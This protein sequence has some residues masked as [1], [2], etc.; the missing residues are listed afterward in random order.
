MEGLSIAQRTPPTLP[1]RTDIEGLRGIAVLLVVLYHAG[2]PGFSGGYIGV[3]VFF[4]L[5]GYLITSILVKEVEETGTVDLLRFYVR[6]ARRLLPAAALL[7]VFV[8]GFTFVF[9][10]PLAQVDM[11]KTAVATAA[12]VSNIFFG[13]RATDYLAADADTNPLLHTWSLSVEEQFYLVWPMLVSVLL[14]GSSAFLKRARGSSRLNRRR[15]TWGMAVVA[16]ASFA[17]TLFLVETGQTH[18]AFFSSPTRVWEF[19]FGG[20]GALVP[21]VRSRPRRTIFTQV[22]GWAGLA[23]I[24]F[25]SS[26]YTE[27]TPFPGWTA[28]LPVLGTVFVLRAGTAQ[29]ERSLAQVL[30][31]RPL[32]F[33]GRLS[34]SWYLWHWPALVFA[35]EFD[36]NLTLAQKLIIVTVSLGFAEMSYRLVEN[37]VRRNPTFNRTSYG[38]TLLSVLAVF[39]L[40]LGASWWSVVA[41]ELR[42]P[43]QKRYVEARADTPRFSDWRCTVQRMETR[44]AGCSDGPADAAF[45]V[46]LFGDSHAAQWA[47][48]LQAVVAERNWRL[49]Y[50]IKVGCPALD[51]T[52]FAKSLGRDYTECDTWR[53][54]AVAAIGDADPDLVVMS[55]FS[56]Y[57]V[58]DAQ[59]WQKGSERIFDALATARAIVVIRDSP[60]PGTDI[61]ACLSRLAWRQKLGVP[62]RETSCNFA[63]HHPN[64]VVA[65]G[66]QREAASTFDNVYLL[67]LTPLLCPEEVCVAE[68][69]ERV[70]FRDRNHLTASYVRSLSARLYR[71]LREV[72]VTL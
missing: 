63:P 53:E 29:T 4:V 56:N 10:A 2:V 25:A 45:T 43:E 6:R 16:A 54:D 12:Y 3:D 9:Y 24:I 8:V 49:L 34:Y 47:P 58:L 23:A 17:L 37:P 59:D 1:W 51:V 18:W 48:A 33:F 64:N 65:F 7:L 19:A 30:S 44:L 62:E 60:H 21:K 72:G 15:L 52:L 41:A 57:G 26:F 66:A 42:S 22:L 40:G 55:S 50:F 39:S 69:A 32:R 46:A 28:L 71:A 36:S 11:A 67:D 38:F 70:L 68:T 5:S 35:A 20:L 13:L 27:R 31:W 61:P 14:V